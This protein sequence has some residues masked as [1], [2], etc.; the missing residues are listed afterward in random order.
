MKGKLAF[1]ESSIT[2][3]YLGIWE[4]MIQRSIRHAKKIDLSDVGDD[5]RLQTRECTESRCYILSDMFEDDC[6]WL[7]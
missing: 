6:S 2:D 7:T 4:D 1:T 3:G 5:S